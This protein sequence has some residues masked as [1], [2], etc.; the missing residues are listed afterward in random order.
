MSMVGILMAD[1]IP[2]SWGLEFVGVL[3]LVTLVVPSLTDV[4]SVVGVVVAA[5][6]AVLARGL[7]LKLSVLVA[8]LAGVAAAIGTEVARERRGP[9]P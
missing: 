9:G 3:A 2:P 8:V 1:R 4:P 6:V 5:A 7:P